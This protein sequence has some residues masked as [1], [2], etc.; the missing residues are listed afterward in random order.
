MTTGAVARGTFPLHPEG[1]LGTG[2]LEACLCPADGSGGQLGSSLRCSRL[3]TGWVMG[4]G[5]QPALPW[6]HIPASDTHRPAGTLS[7]KA[8]QPK[9]RGNVA[10]LQLLTPVLVLVAPWL[11]PPALQPV[12]PSASQQDVAVALG[13]VSGPP[14]T[15]LGTAACLGALMSPAIWLGSHGQAPANPSL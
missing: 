11:H 10:R 13:W 5:P 8:T 12:L 3:H 1:A 15:R 4:S 14:G 6:S 7:T 9:H 2:H